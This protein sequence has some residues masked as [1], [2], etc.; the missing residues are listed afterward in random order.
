VTHG[1]LPDWGQDIGVIIIIRLV[2]CYDWL[3]V[4]ITHDC[5]SYDVI[6]CAHDSHYESWVSRMSLIR[7]HDLIY[8][9]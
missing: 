3:I 7:A 2:D 8:R 1:C 5:K 6:T 4:L 9:L